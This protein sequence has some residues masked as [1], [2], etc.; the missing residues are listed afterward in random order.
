MFSRLPLNDAAVATQAEYDAGDELLLGCTEWSMPRLVAN[1]LP[2][3]FV[4]SGDMILQRFE[5]NDS[6]R[7]IHMDAPTHTAPSEYV[8]LG[9]STGRWDGSTLVVTTTNVTPERLNNAGAPFSKKMTL[10]ERFTPSEDGS[11]LNYA[12]EVTDPENFTERYETERYWDWRPEIIV[13]PYDCD[14]DQQL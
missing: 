3:E 13:G 14:R 10:L 1:P 12:L 8:L 5:E 9:F 6:V 4:R 2:M 7:Q 11:R